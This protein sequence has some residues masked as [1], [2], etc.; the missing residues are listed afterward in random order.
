[1]SQNYEK[2][3]E[4]YSALVAAYPTDDSGLANL[5]LAHFYLLDFGKAL[6]EARRAVQVSPKNMISRNNLALFAMYAGDFATGAAESRQVIDA[7]ASTP[8]TYLPLA[9]EAVMKGDMAA[10]AAAYDGMAATGARGAS[11]ASLGRA[12]LALY[13][14][15]T[16]QAESELQAGI[17][18]DLEAKNSSAAALRHVTLA[19]EQLAV[20]RK[21]QAIDAARAALKLDNQI[22]VVVPAAR[23]LIQAGKAGEARALASGLEAQ[24]PKQNRA[25]GKILLAEIAMDDRA[26][27]RALD[28]LNQAIALSD[29]WLARFDRGVAYVLAGSPA[30]AQPEFETCEKRRG[31]ATALFF[32]DK[33]TVRN[34][35]VLPYWTARAEDGLKMA[36]AKGRYQ[37][38]IDLRKDAAGDPLVQ[39]ARRRLGAR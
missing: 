13:A 28:E 33:P 15:R 25:Y 39:D 32:D 18:A 11:V 37:A 3:V 34:L 4:N 24:V 16:A 36:S 22:G 12:D 27:P 8:S 26:Y 17:A 6:E 35:A 23:V 31:E 30:E 19:E 20:G 29:L 9:M 1:M 14:G 7:K 2:A 38:F 10:A 21:Q 5:A